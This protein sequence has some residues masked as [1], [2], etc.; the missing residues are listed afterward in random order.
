[1][2]KGPF[3]FGS[4]RGEASILHPHVLGNAA[5]TCKDHR[6]FSQ[7][8]PKQGWLPTCEEEQRAPSALFHP[9]VLSSV[10]IAG[11]QCQDCSMPERLC[12]WAS[13]SST[14]GFQMR[15]SLR[16]RAHREPSGSSALCPGQHKAPAE[17]ESLLPRGQWLRVPLDTSDQWWPQ[18]QCWASGVCVSALMTN[19]GI[20]VTPS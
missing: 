17:E 5:E 7:S 14:F 15:V 9:G 3:E 13:K 11:D 1:M 2:F 16:L 19:K 20:K 8:Q 6:C 12:H 10:A 18:G 4:D